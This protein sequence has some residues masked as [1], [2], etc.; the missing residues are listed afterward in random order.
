MAGNETEATKPNPAAS[1]DDDS[2]DKPEEKL[3]P[4]SAKDFKVYNSIAEN[5]DQFV[6]STHRTIKSQPTLQQNT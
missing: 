6:G 5:M 2:R 1:K 4:L 3:P